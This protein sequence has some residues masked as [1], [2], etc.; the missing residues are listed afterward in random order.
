M[1][2]ALSSRHLIPGILQAHPVKYS[3]VAGLHKGWY[4]LVPQRI[5]HLTDGDKALEILSFVYCK[6]TVAGV[7]F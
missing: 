1:R 6:G 7:F 5:P 4:Q 2:H 3:M